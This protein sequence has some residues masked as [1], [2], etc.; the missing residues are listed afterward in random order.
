MLPNCRNE[1]PIFKPFCP[2]RNYPKTYTQSN[3]KN[4]DPQNL[5]SNRLYLGRYRELSV[6][7]SGAERRTH[8]LATHVHTTEQMSHNLTVLSSHPAVATTS[9]PALNVHQR[10]QPAWPCITA[11]CSHT[12]P[13]SC[14][15][16][17]PPF[18]HATTWVPHGAYSTPFNHPNWGC[19]CDTVAP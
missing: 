14:H 19:H 1:G 7:V 18:P 13:H 17:H 5:N 8:P 3:K 15:S 6:V 9:P 2:S 16:E 11:R 12:S 10:T 4:T